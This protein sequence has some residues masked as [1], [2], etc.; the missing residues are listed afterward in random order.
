MRDARRDPVSFHHRGTEETETTI[1]AEHAKRAETRRVPDTIRRGAAKRRFSPGERANESAVIVVVSFAR[2]PGLNPGPAAQ[3][4]RVESTAAFLRS[5][6][7]PWWTV[8]RAISQR[9][10]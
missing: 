1:N 7:P 10:L 6:V 5:S 4:R 3:A 8:L 2:S 9:L